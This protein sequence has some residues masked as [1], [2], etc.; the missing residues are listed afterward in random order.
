MKHTIHSSI[1]LIPKS[2]W[3]KLCEEN[4]PFFDYNFLT[5]LEDGHCLNRE[6]GWEPH[7][8]CI[9]D[10][11]K[12][13]AALPLYLKSH[14]YGEFIFDFAFADAYARHGINYYPKLVA[15]VPV[16]P[17]DGKRFLVANGYSREQILSEFLAAFNK[18]VQ[19]TK[20]S[21]VHFLYCTEE[22]ADLLAKHGFIKRV[23][24]E[25]HWHNQN[26]T[27]FDDFLNAL[28]HKVRAQIKN[29]RAQVKKSGLN[30]QCLTGAAIT[31]DHM[32]AC[33][34]FYIN[35]HHNKYGSPTYLTR[36]FFLNILNTMSDRLLLITACR[37]KTIVAGSI[38]FYKGSGLYGRYWGHTE[39]VPFLHFEL[40]YYQQIEW[41]I[42]NQIKL[43]EAGAQGEHKIKRGLIPQNVYSAHW[44]G[45]QGFHQAIGNFV[46]R[47]HEAMEKNKKF[48]QERSPYKS[49]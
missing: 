26:Y 42:K 5:A 31:E 40:C 4:T 41:A 25:F 18:L 39:D 20:S 22:E 24:F 9:Y 47:E 17:V 16:T 8:I 48:Y 37:D 2:D 43:F 12:L 44:F 27:T 11:S 3:Q 7:Y 38:N 28:T 21:S 6:T 19:D 49:A 32:L 15:T 30:I 13:I 45:N 46:K 23:N 34:N 29:E 36:D 14:S 1:K 33:Y 10:D 35:H